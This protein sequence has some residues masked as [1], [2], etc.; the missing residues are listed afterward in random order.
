MLQLVIRGF[1][2]EMHFYMCQVIYC[3]RVNFQIIKISGNNKKVS[4]TSIKRI[5]NQMTKKIL[6]IAFV[7]SFS[8]FELITPIT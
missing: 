8:D 6:H 3:F 2:F 7:L 4:Y 5:T 1:V